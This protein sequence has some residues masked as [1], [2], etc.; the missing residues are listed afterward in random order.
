MK[1]V[2]DIDENSY[3]ATCSDSML[4]PDVKNVVNA[5]KNGIVL[6]KGHGDLIDRNILLNDVEWFGE[7]CTYENPYPR[8][9]EGVSVDN[10][11]KVPIIISADKGE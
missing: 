5:I 4:P 1:I 11:L 10:I 8:G 9:E 6:S 7:N 3:K 2:I